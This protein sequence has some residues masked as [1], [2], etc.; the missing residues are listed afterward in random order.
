MSALLAALAAACSEF[1]LSTGDLN[2][3]PNPAVPGDLVVAAFG[4]R[5]IP[6]QRHTIVVFI[7][8]EEHTRVTSS[9]APATPVVIELGD[10]A[11]LIATYG[12][13]AHSAYVEVHVPEENART[14]TRSTTFQLN[15]AS[16][17]EATWLRE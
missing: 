14:R 16:P 17:R 5:V 11:A 12:A 2:I 3:A 13:G 6:A 7:D 15:L 1:H 4:V 10:A 9:T 8:D